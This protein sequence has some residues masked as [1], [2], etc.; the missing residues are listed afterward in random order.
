M[1][2]CLER[3]KLFFGKRCRME[4]RSREGKGTTITLSI[5]DVGETQKQTSRLES[6]LKTP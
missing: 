3:L 1:R 4:I 5:K 6:S 2:N